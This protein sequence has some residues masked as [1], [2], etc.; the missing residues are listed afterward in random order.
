MRGPRTLYIGPST[1]KPFPGRPRY[2]AVLEHGVT[3][4]DSLVLAEDCTA[5]LARTLYN[6]AA[7]AGVPVKFYSGL[8]GIAD[9][10]DDE[11][12][13][14]PA[15][16]VVARGVL[17]DQAKHCILGDRNKT[18]GDPG[19]DFACTAKMWAAYLERAHGVT[20]HQP[21]GSC[22]LTP[23]D[24][25]AMM[26]LVKVTRLA[27]TPSHADSWRDTAGYAGCGAEVSGADLG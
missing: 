13:T 15:Q 23:A 12:D 17:L 14:Q 3:A 27:H 7:S 25:A 2:R 10:K 9:L 22:L 26:I 24:V 20:L 16:A 4:D 6:A 21:D 1:S 8:Q 18:Y 11:A 5:S 19:D